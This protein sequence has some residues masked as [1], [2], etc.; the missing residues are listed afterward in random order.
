VI[1]SISKNVG[2]TLYTVK[3]FIALTTN[4]LN[5]ELTRMHIIQQKLCS[6]IANRR[7]LIACTTHTDVQR[8]F[9]RPYVQKL[10]M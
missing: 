7:K 6:I 2:F 5:N 4:E 3:V 10:F 8:Y 1:I 9:S